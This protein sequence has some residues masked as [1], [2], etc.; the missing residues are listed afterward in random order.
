MLLIRLSVVL[1]VKDAYPMLVVV[2]LIYEME[3][4]VF[5]KYFFLHFLINIYNIKKKLTDL[6]SVIFFGFPRDII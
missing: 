5:K 4:D 1:G 6:I 2:V 3:I